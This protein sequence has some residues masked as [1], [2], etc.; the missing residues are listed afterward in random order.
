MLDNVKDAAGIYVMM[1]D[2]VD[3]ELLDA[4]EWYRIGFSLSLPLFAEP[5]GL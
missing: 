3:D 2:R 1:A 4:G 5:D